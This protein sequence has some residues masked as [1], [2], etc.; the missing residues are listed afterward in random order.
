MQTWQYESLRVI[1]EQN[2]WL[3]ATRQSDN[4]TII[5]SRDWT[6]SQTID[7]LIMFSKADTSDITRR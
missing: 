5:Q 4:H 2:E 3:A 1:S 6:D 7:Q